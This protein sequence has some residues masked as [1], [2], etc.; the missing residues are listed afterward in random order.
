MRDDDIRIT[1]TVAWMPE[2]PKACRGHV[3]ARAYPDDHILPLF[4]LLAKAI[5]NAE[6]RNWFTRSIGGRAGSLGP[7]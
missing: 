4:V 6:A 1:D 2:M 3:D 7:R 5:W